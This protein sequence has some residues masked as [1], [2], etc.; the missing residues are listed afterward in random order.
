[1]MKSLLPSLF[2][3]LGLAL[4][5]LAADDI[6]LTITRAELACTENAAGEPMPSMIQLIFDKSLK[7]DELMPCDSSDVDCITAQEELSRWIKSTLYTNTNYHLVEVASGNRSY[8]YDNRAEAPDGILDNTVKFTI[9][10]AAGFIPY[11]PAKPHILVAKNLTQ[12]KSEPFMIKIAPNAS[13]EVRK[14]NLASYDKPKADQEKED[15]EKR[16][17]DDF[18]SKPAI[19]ES[20]ALKLDF[21]LSGAKGKKLVY[22]FNVDFRPY[23]TRRL[24]FGG[25]YELNYFFFNTEY[26]INAKD[27]DKKNVLNI[28]A[29]D[30]R[31]TKVFRDDGDEYTNK[32]VRHFP[33]FTFSATPKFETE[34]GFDEAKFLISPAITFP[35]N[36]Y[37]S[38][39]TTLQ[40]NPFAGIDVGP[41]LR[42]QIT[43][44]TMVLRPFFGAGLT[45][46]F[47]RKNDKPRFAGQI[48]YTRRLFIRSELVYGLDANE[49]EVFL[50]KSKLPR[51]HVKARIVYNPSEMFSPFL[52]YEY[53]FVPPK[54]IEIDSSFRMGIVLN[55]DLVWKSFK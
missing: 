48:D 16:K 22:Y 15:F 39:G 12:G 29:L 36:L 14:A 20:P 4:T 13:C 8:I 24:G 40:I 45:A 27:G 54:Y 25:H 34:W 52:E 46:N 55:A 21:S 17:L 49:K 23:T 37:Q 35:I 44:K 28:G 26:R 53:G 6:A 38:R 5:A 47:F 9:S 51:D 2:M 50:G 19:E 41:T 3:I 30:F 18:F 33:A 42:S 32:L 11:D 43:K 10:S 7:A 1:M 31:W